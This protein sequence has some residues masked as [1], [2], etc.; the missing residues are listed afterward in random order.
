MAKT[1]ESLA[2]RLTER[3][4]TY[5]KKVDE[6]QR[7]VALVVDSALV[8]ATPVDTGRARSNWITTTGKRANYSV[9]PYAPG[10]NLGIGE[11]A[12]AS[13]TMA[14]AREALKSHASGEAIFL[15]NN[16]RYI[17][18]LNQGTSPQAP[19]NFVQIQVR[20]AVKA[21]SR[22]EIARVWIQAGKRRR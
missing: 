10:E 17:G 12:N 15:T 2:I 19:K 9:L 13:A 11:S 7:Q 22:S 16:V 20:S 21:F 5:Q 6:L 1:F 14:Q 8:L 18:D 4:K 3:A